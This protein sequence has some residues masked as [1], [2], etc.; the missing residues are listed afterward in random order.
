MKRY[1]IILNSID[2]KEEFLDDMQHISNKNHVPHRD[3]ECFRKRPTSKVCTFYLTEEEALLVKQDPRVHDSHINPADEPAIE[4]SIDDTFSLPDN[5]IGPEPPEDYTPTNVLNLSS[6]I[7]FN[8]I[9]D[10]NIV[11]VDSNLD[12]DHPEFDRIVYP[13]PLNR[14]RT[15]SRF[16]SRGVPINWWA[17]DSLLGNFHSQ[18]YNYDR[19]TNRIDAYHGTH[20]ASTIA[21]NINGWAKNSNLFSISFY[22]Y[23]NGDSVADYIRA[24]HNNGLIDGTLS[25]N[26]LNRYPDLRP[27]NGTYNRTKPTIVNNSWGYRLNLSSIP[28]RWIDTIVYRNSIFTRPRTGWDLDF[29]T[30]VLLQPL[31]FIQE[32]QEW[33]LYL[34]PF[35]VPAID[36]EV[37]EMIQDGIIHATAAGNN[38]SY[39]VDPSHIDWNNHYIFNQNTPNLPNIVRNNNFRVFMHQ[40]ASPM[41]GTIKVGAMAPGERKSLFSNY[42]PAVDIFAPGSNIAG[43]VNL[44]RLQFDF[45]IVGYP[46]YREYNDLSQEYGLAKLN[47]TSM[48]CP[49]VCGVLALVAANS[50]IVAN[51]ADFD[52]TTA[53]NWLYNI[54][55][56]STIDDPGPRTPDM[57]FDTRYQCLQGAPNRYLYYPYATIELSNDKS[58]SLAYDY[59]HD[60]LFYIDSDLRMY[61]YDISDIENTPSPQLLNG[62]ESP[63]AQPGNA[64]Y[65]NNAVW[66]FEYN[67]NVLV[68]LTLSYNNNIPSVSDIRKWFVLNMGLPTTGTV[69]DNTNTFGDIAIT[70]DGQ[71]IACTSRGRMYTVN[72]LPRFVVG[73][74][75]GSFAEIKSSEGNDKSVGLQLSWNDRDKILYGHNFKTGNWYIV[76]KSDGSKTSINIASDRKYR[77]LAGNSNIVYGIDENGNLDILNM[78]FLLP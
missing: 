62:F 16:P 35:R 36:V 64:A 60:M 20:V 23:G 54:G 28:L 72:I 77:D 57:D 55:S 39:T 32:T 7:D 69:G 5:I 38:Y 17:Y 48:A 30:N 3:C 50:G 43:A 56:L 8:A 59:D 25:L 58:N 63:T 40:G 33:S 31:A 24:F 44:N 45:D 19:N 18:P 65:W 73:R 27:I 37:D 51:P 10:A 66:Y 53:E 67:S 21:G 47:G 26:D 74:S 34:L 68:R 6:S 1:D 11:V 9:D 13:P 76:N 15:G 29:F 46:R 78:Q 2:D 22:D 61:Y 12:F 49:Q 52:Q 71:L 75:I 70:N 14:N 42:G 4:F 41:G